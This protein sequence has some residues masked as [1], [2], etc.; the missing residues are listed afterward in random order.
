MKVKAGLVVQLE[1]DLKVKDGE[2]IESSKKSG[3]VA[4]THGAGQMLAGLEKQLEGMGAGDEKQ[5]VIAATDAFGSEK[6][7]VTMK[8]PRAEF[9]KDTKIAAGDRFEAKGPTGAPVTLHV[10]DVNAETV[11]AKVVHPLADKDIEFR[12]KVVSVKPP[13]PKKPVAI[14]EIEPDADSKK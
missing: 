9:P 11:T 10:T 7:Q 12:V 13:L 2:V 4:Y 1:V 5:G 3:L 14:E 8:V 6:S